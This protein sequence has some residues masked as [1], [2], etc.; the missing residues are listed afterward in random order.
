MAEAARPITHVIKPEAIGKASRWQGYAARDGLGM[1]RT[2]NHIKAAKPA[3]GNNHQGQ[4]KL[5]CDLIILPVL[6]Q[7]RGLSSFFRNDIIT[8]LL[9]GVA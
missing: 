8:L 1:T 7:K 3:N 2:K 4:R 9:N 6:G 5:R